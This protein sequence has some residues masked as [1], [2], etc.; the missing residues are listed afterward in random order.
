MLKSLVESVTVRRHSS[1]SFAAG[2]VVAPNY[3][4]FDFSHYQP[5]TA[6]E[7]EEIER[8]V[9]YHILRNE[10]VQTDEMAI[11]EAVRRTRGRALLEASGGITIERVAE[12]ARAGVDAISVGALTHSAPALDVSL[13]LDPT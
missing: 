12:L 4:R 1:R 3:L 5:L 8:L 9:N 7:K 13:L 6:A 10:P 2:S 11:E